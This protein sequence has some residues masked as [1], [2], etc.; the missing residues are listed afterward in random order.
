MNPFKAV[1]ERLRDEGIAGLLPTAKNRTSLRDLHPDNISDP[2][3]PPGYEIQPDQP[4]PRT[5]GP[6][7]GIPYPGDEVTTSINPDMPGALQREYYRQAA[8]QHHMEEGNTPEEAGRRAA[9]RLQERF[10]TLAEQQRIRDAY[11]G[12]REHF[13]VSHM[14]QEIRVPG[15]VTAN[16]N[17]YSGSN[18]SATREYPPLYPNPMRSIQGD[19]MALTSLT[20]FT[21]GSTLS[22]PIS[23]PCQGCAN[24]STVN[25]YC[26][27]CDRAPKDPEER[28][29]GA[30][31]LID[32]FISKQN[33]DY[34]Y[35]EWKTKAA[36]KIKEQA[37]QEILDEMKEDKKILKRKVLKNIVN[38]GKHL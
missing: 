2:M 8:I 31:P 34:F 1:Y 5:D 25:N 9:I 6:T 29:L 10:G 19:P 20:S 16:L 21:G 35:N 30:L 7:P 18:L 23:R 3:L 26:E 38:N 33:Q 24:E 27:A 22:Q 28:P 11:T 37:R 13:T 12:T 14:G 4:W 36:H 15:A 32:R 17:D